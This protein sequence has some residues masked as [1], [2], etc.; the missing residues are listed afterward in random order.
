MH[1]PMEYLKIQRFRKLLTSSV[2]AWAFRFCTICGNP[3]SIIWAANAPFAS[4]LQ[5]DMT[6]TLTTFNFIY[7]VNIS[8][9][10]GLLGWVPMG[11]KPKLGHAKILVCQKNLAKVRARM[12]GKVSFGS[13]PTGCQSF[14]GNVLI[15]AWHI[16]ALNQAGP[17]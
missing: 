6:T 5:K 1:F 16:L 15:L 4:K 11:A 7:Y 8:D 14:I 10:K 12:S 3:R 2:Q 13:Q 9:M 17:K